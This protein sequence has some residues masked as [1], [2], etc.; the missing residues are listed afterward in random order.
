MQLYSQLP[1]LTVSVCVSMCVCSGAAGG[2]ELLAVRWDRSGLQVAGWPVQ[3]LQGCCMARPALPCWGHLHT[4]VSLLAP[5]VPAGQQAR[6][7]R[8]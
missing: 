8:C 4:D 2:G 6:S 5:D 1:R 7:C 3:L